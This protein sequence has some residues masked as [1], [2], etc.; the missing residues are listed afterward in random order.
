MINFTGEHD[1]KVDAKGR[2]MLPIAFR[3]Q[4][5]EEEAYCF[6]VKKDLYE[7]CLELYTVAEWERQNKLVMNNY[8]PFNPDDRQFLRDFRMGA[9]EVECD[10]TGRIL[11]PR[12]LLIQV[13]IADEVVLSGSIG[14]IEIWSPVLYNNSGGD[15]SAKRDRAERIMGDATYNTELL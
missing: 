11:I 5:G 2:I 12:R 6:V 14:K 1:C 3:R 8:K 9:T 13:E 15:I 10:P 7:P 4:M